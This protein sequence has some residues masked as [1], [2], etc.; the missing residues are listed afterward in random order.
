MPLRIHS[1]VAASNVHVIRKVRSAN[2]PRLRDRFPRARVRSACRPCE[3]WVRKPRFLLSVDRH[4]AAAVVGSSARTS[5]A[6]ARQ[7][8]RERCRSWRARSSADRERPQTCRAR[9]RLMRTMGVNA[10]LALAGGPV[11]AAS[12][13]LTPLHA[14][15]RSAPTTR[16]RTASPASMPKSSGSARLS[17]LR[18][19]PSLSCFCLDQILHRHKRRTTVRSAPRPFSLAP[20]CRRDRP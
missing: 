11:I 20:R 18:V 5:A 15:R 9:A 2:G 8:C 19:A 10:V 6:A 13:T 12:M 3:V 1:A 7:S 16:S 17:T 14:G 4:R